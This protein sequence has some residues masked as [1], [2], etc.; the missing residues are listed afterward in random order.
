MVFP[1]LGVAP[2]GVEFA[3]DVYFVLPF[4]CE[5]GG[6]QANLCFCRIRFW[7]REEGEDCMCGREVGSDY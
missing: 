1:A 4:S 2:T 3:V 7:V 6:S 5:A